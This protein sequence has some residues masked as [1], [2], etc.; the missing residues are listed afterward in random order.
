MPLML[1]IR[2]Y[3]RVKDRSLRSRKKRQCQ[4]RTNFAANKLMSI[5]YVLTKYLL[6]TFV[7]VSRFASTDFII[8]YVDNL[9]SCLLYTSDAADE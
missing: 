1:F 5:M 3:L 2:S 8:K 6:N 9:R 4:R 7:V